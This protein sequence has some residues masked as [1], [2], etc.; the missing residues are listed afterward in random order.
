MCVCVC[1]C[2]LEVKLG[3][4]HLRRIPDLRGRWAPG[5]S[6]GEP[7]RFWLRAP[8]APR[9]KEAG[10]AAMGLPLLAWL[11]CVSLLGVGPTDSALQASSSVSQREML[12]TLG[13]SG[14]SGA[15][16]RD[17]ALQGPTRLGADAWAL[18]EQ[19]TGAGVSGVTAGSCPE[20][21]EGPW[22]AARCSAVR[23]AL[24]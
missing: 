8:P 1:V 21:P 24:G 7:S 10:G 5:L 23:R 14:S 12:Q 11:S 16:R 17:G 9:S 22:A 4:E 18:K 6:Q 15:G 2:I 13:R 20:T 19:C 3:A